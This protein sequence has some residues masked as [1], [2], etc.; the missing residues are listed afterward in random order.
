MHGP[1]NIKKENI[2]PDWVLDAGLSICALYQPL[3]PSVSLAS[4]YCTE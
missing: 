4:V 1:M 3:I 2:L